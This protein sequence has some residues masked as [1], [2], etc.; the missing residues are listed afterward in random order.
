MRVQ[1]LAQQYTSAKIAL[2]NL[3]DDIDTVLGSVG[4]PGMEWHTD[5]YDMSIEF[6]DVVQ[7]WVLSPA[8]EAAIQGL[9]FLNCWLN[10]PPRFP[11][12]K[13]DKHYWWLS[14]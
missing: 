1:N 11:N 12:E 2:E 4:M 7:D 8:Q 3:Q 9:G 14:E 13:N 10:Y 5:S 6:T